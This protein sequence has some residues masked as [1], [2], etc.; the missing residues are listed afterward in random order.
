MIG[1]DP[2]IGILKNFY[3]IAIKNITLRGIFGYNQ[4][5][6]KTA[7][8]LL[9]QKRIDVKPLITNIIGIEDVPNSFKSLAEKEH[10]DVKILVK[11]R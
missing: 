2:E 11:I 7:I 8:E 10:E 9:E 6:F 1:M 3:G 4:D 5:T